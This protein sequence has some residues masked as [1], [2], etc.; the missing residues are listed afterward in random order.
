MRIRLVALLDPGAAPGLAGLGRAPDVLAVPWGRPAHFGAVAARRPALLPD[1]RPSAWRD[2]GK[3]PVGHPSEDLIGPYKALL[4]SYK[5]CK[6]VLRPYK[7][8]KALLRPYKAYKA[9]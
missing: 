9:L 6:A 4:R 3:G 2:P 5:A 7:A 8:Y 1:P